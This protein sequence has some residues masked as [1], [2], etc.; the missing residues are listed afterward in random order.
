[1]VCPESALFARGLTAGRLSRGNQ[2]KKSQVQAIRTHFPAAGKSPW[3]FFG[4]G[5]N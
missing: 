1:M 2:G 5:R 4:L 3:H